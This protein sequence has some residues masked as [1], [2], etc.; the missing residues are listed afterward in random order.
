[1]PS[2]IQE[3]Q[4]GVSWKDS[5]I[6]RKKT[7]LG[8]S[9]LLQ[10]ALTSWSS[11]TIRRNPPSETNWD[12]QSPLTLGLNS[13][14]CP[15]QVLVTCRLMAKNSGLIFTSLQH[16]VNLS[17]WSLEEQNQNKERWMK[18]FIVI[19]CFNVI[20]MLRFSTLCY[21]CFFMLHNFKVGQSLGIK[22]KKSAITVCQYKLINFSE[23][24]ILNYLKSIRRRFKIRT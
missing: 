24:I 5:L 19:K 9:Q 21:V 2:R 22:T 7:P 12:M 18:D 14:E 17:S 23:W 10:H 16:C 15:T 1:M 6:W 4:L 11:Q 8:V 3:T 20:Q 13:P